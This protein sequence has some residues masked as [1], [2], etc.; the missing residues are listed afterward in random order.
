MLQLLRKPCEEP[1]SLLPVCPLLHK[2][3]RLVMGPYRAGPP[4]VRALCSRMA[5]FWAF[6]ACWAFCCWA[7]R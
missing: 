6:L 7:P 1:P 3:T 5:L 4:L 2:Y